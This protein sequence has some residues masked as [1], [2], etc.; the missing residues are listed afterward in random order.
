MFDMYVLWTDTDGVLWIGPEPGPGVG[1]R[2]TADGQ[3]VDGDHVTFM[4]GR[5]DRYTVASDG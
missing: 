4:N 3:M 5:L 1:L 2:V